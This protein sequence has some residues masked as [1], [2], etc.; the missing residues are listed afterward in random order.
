M[1]TSQAESTFSQNDANILEE[2]MNIAFGKASADLARVVDIRILLTAPRVEFLKAD[3][4]LQWIKQDTKTDDTLNMIEQNFWGKYTGSAFLAF[5]SSASKGLISLFDD[6]DLSLGAESPLLEKET[7]LE[8][9]NILI[10][11]CVGKVAELLDDNVSFSPPRLVPQVVIDNPSTTAISS[12]LNDPDKMAIMI[13][14]V[15]NFED[16]DVK[17]FLFLVAGEES[18]Q[19]LKAA[20]KNFVAKF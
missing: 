5:P 3:D 6:D 1:N 8:V 2:V 20:L 17:G 18:M 9:G 15:F 14:T 19:W 13:K 10:G 12:K 11:A 16:K 7:L 4:L